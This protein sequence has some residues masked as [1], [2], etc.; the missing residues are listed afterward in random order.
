MLMPIDAEDDT[1]LVFASAGD[2]PER[3]EIEAEIATL[4]GAD[5]EPQRIQLHYLSGRVEIEVLLSSDDWQRIDHEALRQHIDQRLAAHPAYRD[6]T[7]FVRS[8][9]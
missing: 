3:A 7:F 5:M 6:I 9:P 2:M 1:A 4:L 8:A